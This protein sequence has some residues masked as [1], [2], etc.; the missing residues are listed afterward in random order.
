MAINGIAKSARFS[1]ILILHASCREHARSMFLSLECP[2]DHCKGGDQVWIGV[3]EG[4][5]AYQYAPSIEQVFLYFLLR[6]QPHIAATDDRDN[7][8]VLKYACFGCVEKTRDR[9]RWVEE[10]WLVAKNDQ[11][12]F[13]VQYLWR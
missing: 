13:P 9:L 6:M 7:W 2:A 11:I 12:I 4:N 1:Y 10:P 3:G 8:C 5:V